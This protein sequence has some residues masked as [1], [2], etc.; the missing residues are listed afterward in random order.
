MCRRMCVEQMR[1]HP[2]TSID[3]VLALALEPTVL[4]LVA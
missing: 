2:V 3:E 1:F 4:A